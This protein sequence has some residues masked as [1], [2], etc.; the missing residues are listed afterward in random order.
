[1]ETNVDVV[2]S[3]Y[4]FVWKAGTTA[5]AKYRPGGLKRSE[6]IVVPPT[7]VPE[8]NHVA[9]ALVELA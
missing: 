8:F 3:P 4:E 1:V 7:L 5:R 9:S 2:G 6:R